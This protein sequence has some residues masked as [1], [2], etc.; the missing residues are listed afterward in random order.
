M[1]LLTCVVAALVV[2]A[3]IGFA[4]RSQLEKQPVIPQIPPVYRPPLAIANTNVGGRLPQEQAQ[5]IADQAAAVQIRDP[6]GPIRLATRI[7]RSNGA[8]FPIP[9]AIPVAAE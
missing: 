2:V 4:R 3:A 9:M 5:A 6:E 1:A 7:P 8:A